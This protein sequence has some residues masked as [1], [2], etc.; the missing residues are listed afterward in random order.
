[1]DLSNFFQEFI[2]ER[3][4]SVLI[5]RN[6]FASELQQQG[7]T[8]MGLVEDM[9]SYRDLAMTAEKY[10]GKLRPHWGGGGEERVGAPWILENNALISLNPLFFFLVF[11]FAVLP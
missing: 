8:L 3:E 11:F 1:M 7:R 9:K 5:L 10:G 6:Q 4:R 2:D